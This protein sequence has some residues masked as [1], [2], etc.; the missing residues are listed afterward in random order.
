M[1]EITVISTIMAFSA[2][3]FLPIFGN[4]AR[5]HTLT[6]TMKIGLPIIVFSYVFILFC[7]PANGMIMFILYWVIYTLGCAAFSLGTDAIIFEMV[8]EKHRTTAIA[9]KNIIA[10]PLGFLTTTA[11]TPLLS[12]IQNNGNK[13]FGL[14]IYGQQLFALFAMVIMGIACL[15]FFS[16]S[17]TH[18]PE[19][20]HG[21]EVKDRI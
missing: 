18:T 6:I 14:N 11:L 17:K 10:G 20:Q 13:I 1:M 5:R 19:K 12:Y 16:F 21:D 9:M 15:L 3:L 4:Y 7:T 2:I 8:D